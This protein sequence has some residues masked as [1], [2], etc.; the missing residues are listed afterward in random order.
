[1]T[2]IWKDVVGYKGLYEVSNYGRI[3]THKDKT[4]FTKLHGK[5][6]WKQ[7]FLK[8]KTP[9][10][11]DVRVTLWKDGKP[12]DYLAHRLV[13]FAFIPTVPNKECINHID[14]NPQNNNVKNLE[15]CTHKENVNHAFENGLHSSNMAVKLINHIGIEYQFISMK[16]A[17]IFLGR[18]HS[19]VSAKIRQGFST[20]TDING[21]HFRVE[22]LV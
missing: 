7:R 4:T 8:N 21:N 13:A 19:Y 10:G 1:M 20:I 2:E 16:R 11:R 3:R 12:K 18:G 9:N 5:R 22:K 15:W 17:S 14:G 6:K